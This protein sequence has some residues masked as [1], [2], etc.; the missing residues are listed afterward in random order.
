MD[1]L[2]ALDEIIHCKRWEAERYGEPQPFWKNFTNAAVSDALKHCAKIARKKT[3]KFENAA[4][5]KRRPLHQ[6]SS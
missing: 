5:E 4:R 2:D 3:I 1:A 6:P